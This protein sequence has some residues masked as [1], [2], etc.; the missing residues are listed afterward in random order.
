MS[1]SEKIE[2]LALTLLWHIQTPQPVCLC[3]FLFLY[4][5]CDSPLQVLVNFLGLAREQGKAL[6]W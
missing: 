1:K 4:I 2:Y 3:H 5:L 6:K